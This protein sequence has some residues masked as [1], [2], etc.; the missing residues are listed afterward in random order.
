MPIANDNFW[1]DLNTGVIY[2]SFSIGAIV[3]VDITITGDLYYHYKPQQ[4]QL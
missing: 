2:G 1:Y 4:L 3:T